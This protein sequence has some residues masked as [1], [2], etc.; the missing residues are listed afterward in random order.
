M[1]TLPQLPEYRA[2]WRALYFET[3]PGS[4]ERFTFAIMARGQDGQMDIRDTLRPGALRTLF[5]PQGEVMH[6]LMIR[7]ILAIKKRLDAQEDWL[8]L[9][10]I[11][12]NIQ[13]G[14]VRDTLADN[15]EQVFDQAVRLSASLGH[16]SI[17]ASVSSALNLD[18]ELQSWAGRIKSFVEA[19]QAELIKNFNLNIRE[20]N[21]KTIK[22]KIG[23]MYGNYAANFGVIHTRSDR[24]SGDIT[25]IKKK[26]WD[27]DQLRHNNMAPPREVE[28]IVGHAPLELI[29][30][31]P[32]MMKTL[33]DKLDTLSHEAAN[34]NIVVFKTSDVRIAAEHIVRKV[35]NA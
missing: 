8:Q 17:G 33:Q 35:A 16:S 12:S 18:E 14:P 22:A 2:Q 30:T 28:I 1:I 27:L 25:A 6:G 32:R 7:A 19:M 13:P 21:T 5:G 10:F 4:G 29:K 26:L 15:F 31:Q 9:P 23:F 20:G 3:I 24:I 11:L 34:K